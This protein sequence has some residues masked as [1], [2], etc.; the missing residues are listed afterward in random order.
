MKAIVALLAVLC[1]ALNANAA[2]VSKTDIARNGGKHRFWPE[3][4]EPVKVLG[5]TFVGG[6]GTEFLVGGGF[7][8]DGT[9]IL[10]GNSL[11]PKLGRI[12][13]Q[14]GVGCTV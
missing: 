5:A 2:P 7:Q 3:P 11:G 14:N 12:E 9:I 4:A 8:A 6:T 1:G 13:K 10:V